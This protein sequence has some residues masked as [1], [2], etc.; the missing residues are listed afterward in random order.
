M[1]TRTCKE[2]SALSPM[3]GVGSKVTWQHCQMGL[4]PVGWS[5]NYRGYLCSS[6]Q[7]N[8]PHSNCGICTWHYSS[9]LWRLISKVRVLLSRVQ[10]KGTAFPACSSA[11]HCAFTSPPPLTGTMAAGPVIAKDPKCHP[12]EGRTAAYEWGGEAHKHP[13]HN[14]A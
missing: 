4:W 13:L 2:S 11:W 5:G 9:Q 8:A 6:C 14:K 3:V 1:N 10:K 12:L 7:N